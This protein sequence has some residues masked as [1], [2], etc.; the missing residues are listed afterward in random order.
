VPARIWNAYLDQLVPYPGP[1]AQANTF[2]S[3]GY[4]YEFDSFI[5]VDHLALGLNDQFQPAA[6]FLGANKVDRDPAH[7]TYAV[8][9]KMQEPAFGFVG[10]HAYWLSRISVRNGSGTA[11]LGTV[12]VRSEGFGVGDPPPGGTTPGVG[13]LTGGFFLAAIP[14]N[15][16]SKSWG[17]APAAPIADVLDVNGSNISDVTVNPQRARVSCNV[18]VRITSDGPMT[19]HIPACGRDIVFVPAGSGPAGSGGPGSL[20][21]T[22]GSSPTASWLVAT[23]IALSVTVAARRRR[24][25]P[26]PARAPAPPSAKG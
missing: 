4:R 13:A 12:D 8:N 18:N 14:F 5:G 7:V 16:Q 26:G 11:P 9:P 21:N 3:L 1:L 22:S 23:A 2:D 6:D 19:V 15:S 25:R 10:D 17:P 20:P 24:R